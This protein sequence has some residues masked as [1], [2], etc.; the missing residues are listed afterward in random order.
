MG[1]QKFR[2]SIDKR[3]KPSERQAIA[4]AI[5]DQIQARTA[6][7]KSVTGRQFPGYTDEY[8]KRKGQGNVDLTFSG[9]MLFNSLKLLSESSGTILI[10]Y[11]NGTDENAKAEGNILGTYGQKRPIPGKK[12]NFLGIQK[13]ELDQILSE[14]PLE[15]EE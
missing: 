9:D 14:F 2:I 5:I 10:G 4:E 8:R 7:G 11:E 12:R 15:T 13:Q 3:Y 6:S 1:W